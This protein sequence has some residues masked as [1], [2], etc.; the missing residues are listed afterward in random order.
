MAQIQEGNSNGGGAE[1]SK[2]LKVTKNLQRKS[3]KKPSLMMK[4][5]ATTKTPEI[6]KL[7]N[8]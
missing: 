2:S 7:I 6:Q 3:N 4:G 1:R 8:E 5:D